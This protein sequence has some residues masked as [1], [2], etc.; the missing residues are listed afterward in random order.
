MPRTATS[1]GFAARTA[2][3]QRVEILVDQQIGADLARD[4]GFGA[5]G[6]D[7]LALVRHVDPVDVRIAHRRARRGEVH[8]LR[9]GLAR[10][11]DD[12]ARRRAAN[13]RVVDEQH[14]LVPEFHADRIEL[15]AH[16]LPAQGLARHD[17]RAP[18]VAVLDEA[19]AIREPE[20]V[21]ELQRRGAARVRDRNHDVDVRAP[22]ESRGSWPP[23]CSPMLSRDS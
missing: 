14:D 23:S 13:D 22:R 11:L 15:L 1:A 19:L 21:R 17:E 10:H 6:G 7:E 20:R 9:A 18:D 2:T 5:A 8:L 4:F 16:A 3:L 12:L